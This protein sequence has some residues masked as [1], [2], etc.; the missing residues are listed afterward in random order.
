MLIFM[1][2]SLSD[3][4]RA[5]GFTSLEGWGTNTLYRRGV[6]LKIWVLYMSKTWQV[7]KYF[8]E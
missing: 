2:F 1:P 7:L 4:G 5:L 3:G 8:A 6:V